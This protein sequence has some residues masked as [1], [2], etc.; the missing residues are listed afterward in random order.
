MTPLEKNLLET[1]LHNCRWAEPPRGQ[2]RA[3][4]GEKKIEE[5]FNKTTVRKTFKIDQDL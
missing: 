5:E 2:K 4:R 3:E 1:T